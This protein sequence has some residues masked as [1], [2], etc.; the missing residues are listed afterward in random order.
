M[1]L[2]SV[3]ADAVFSMNSGRKWIKYD[4][5]DFK[6]QPQSAN[7]FDSWAWLLSLLRVMFF[8]VGTFIL[9]ITTCALCG[10]ACMLSSVVR[11][12]Y[13]NRR[14]IRQ[15]DEERHNFEEQFGDAGIVGDC[16]ATENEQFLN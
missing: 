11:D 13:Y 9:L 7:T 14:Q 12:D 8:I 2:E 16:F 3:I 5:S 10:F 1:L 6:R 15:R 4:L